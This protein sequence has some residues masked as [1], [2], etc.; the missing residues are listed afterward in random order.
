MQTS[1]LTY[2]RGHKTSS[3]RIFEKLFDGRIARSDLVADSVSLA[4]L[5]VPR[6][7]GEFW[8]SVQRQ[9]SS[10][11]EVSYRAC[12][13]PQLPRFFVDRLTQPGEAVYDPF[14]GRGMT[15]IEVALLGMLVIGNANPPGRILA[16]LRL[17]P[18]S[19]EDVTRRIERIEVGRRVSSSVKLS[20]FYHPRTDSE[21]LSPRRYLAHRAVSGREDNVD[22]WI[23]MVATNVE[24]PDEMV[25]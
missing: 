1:R 5:Q 7:A 18:P 17:L 2:H 22:R 14:M 13:K 16:K 19:L 20:R 11:H 4:G 23:R 24:I 9:A 8:T 10:L 3:Q 12:F 21:I 25:L 6:F 15:P